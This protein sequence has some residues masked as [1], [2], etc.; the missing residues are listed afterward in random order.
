M[1]NLSQK[2]KKHQ[3][4][5]RMRQKQADLSEIKASLVC[6][7]SLGQPGICSKKAEE[8]LVTWLSQGPFLLH[9]ERKSTVGPLYQ[10]STE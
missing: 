8:H 5:W 2:A 6:R 9:K 10:V 1:F 3:A 4:W 7:A